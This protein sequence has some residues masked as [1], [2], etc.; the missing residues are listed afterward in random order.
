MTTSFVWEHKQNNPFALPDLRI[1]LQM[2]KCPEIFNSA[3]LDG[4]QSYFRGSITTKNNYLLFK[5][6]SAFYI[7]HFLV[8][9]KLAIEKINSVFSKDRH[10]FPNLVEFDAVLDLYEVLYKF[11]SKPRFSMAGF[12]IDHDLDTIEESEQLAYVKKFLAVDFVSVKHHSYL[13]KSGH[14]I[15]LPGSSADGYSS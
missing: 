7:M 4:L 12:C 8:N 3:L 1:R 5:G 10:N 2:N 13:F 15:W 9:S 6:S 14:H 11:D